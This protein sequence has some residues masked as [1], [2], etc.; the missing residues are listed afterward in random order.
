MHNLIL[1]GSNNN[2]RVAN[3]QFYKIS[4][5]M[6]NK[7]NGQPIRNPFQNFNVFNNFQ[8]S[9]FNINIP[10]EGLG[11]IMSFVQSSINNVNNNMMNGNQMHN[12]R[13]FNNDMEDNYE[14]EDSQYEEEEDNEGNEEMQD[15]NEISEEEKYFNE[16]KERIKNLNEFQFKNINLYFKDFATNQALKER[17]GRCSICLSDFIGT[18]IVKQFSCDQHIFHK[19]C[20]LNWLKNSD[21][22]PLCKESIMKG[23]P[24]QLEDDQNDM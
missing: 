18:D 7:I 24:Y 17:V 6:N 9:N 3:D 2:L 15:P 11:N 4:N 12:V 23:Y 14:D 20:L 16:K 1:N 13:I 5:G 22:C 19:R 8:N 10:F 21:K